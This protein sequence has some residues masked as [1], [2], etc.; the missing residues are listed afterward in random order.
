[1]NVLKSAA[2]GCLL[3]LASAAAWADDLAVDY[4]RAIKQDNAVRIN[5]LLRD[6]LDPNARNE[7][8]TPG[9]VLALQE[10][11]LRAAQAILASNRLDLEART[12]SDENALMMAALKGQVDMVR[13][14]LAKGASVNKPGW[15]PLHYAATGGNADIIGLLLDRR[16]SLEARSPNDTTPLMMAARY[17][18]PQGVQLLLRAGADPL[19]RNQLGMDA[20]DF[21]A[22]AERPD[23]VALLTEAK[24]RAPVRQSVGTT[25]RPASIQPSTPVERAAASPVQATIQATQTTPGVAQQVTPSS[26]ATTTEPAASST[27]PPP[28]STAVTS[29]GAA[30]ITTGEGAVLQ[31]GTPD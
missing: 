5:G 6:G 19:A 28:S 18:S 21:A 16:A 13:A 9:L 27:P 7:H 30:P 22:S 10:E 24:R 1:M 17:G 12:A 3:A 14:L 2:L 29:G 15:T 31:M 26:A 23:A 20:L 11:A 8:G 4:V 25:A